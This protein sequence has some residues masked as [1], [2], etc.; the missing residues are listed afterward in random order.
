M[1]KES[2]EWITN[3]QYLLVNEKRRTAAFESGSLY[4]HMI[5]E[6]H[7]M[8]RE[9]EALIRKLKRELADSH[10]ETVNV[11]NIWMA[12]VDDMEKESIEQKNKDE[13]ALKAMELRA[14]TAEAKNAANEEKIRQQRLENYELANR[15]EE[16]K[17]K[18]QKLTAQL[19]HDYENSSLPSSMCIKKKKIENSREKTERKPGGQPGH[20]GHSRKKQEATT[21]IKLPAPEEIRNDPD[22]KKTKRTIKKQVVGI[23]LV[24][25]V[26]EYQADVYYNSKTGEYRHAEFPEEAVCDVNYDGSIKAFLYL[27]NTDC[28]VSIDKCSKFLSDLTA[29]KLKISKGMING[30]GKE[31]TE[32]TESEQK[33]LFHR[34]LISPV[35][36]TDC[37]NGSIN[38]ENAY[39]IVCATPDGEAMYFSR[40][41]KG[42]KAVAGT[43]VEEYQGILVHDHES[44]F[45]NYGTKHQECL[46][47]ILRC[48][49]DSMSNEPDRKWN[50][51]MYDL[52][53]EMIHYRNGIDPETGSDQKKIAGYEEKYRQI[54]QMAKEEYEYI[55]ASQY[56]RDGYN[57]YIRME[58]HPENHLLFLHD[59]RVPANNNLAERTLRN[60]KR[61]QKQAV[62]F[63]SRE[64]HDYLCRGM[65]ML[66]MMRKNETNLFDRVSRIL[67]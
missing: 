36:H 25:E 32:K 12:T 65:S 9:Y 59:L 53:R 3:L 35:M 13:K 55:P 24:L 26:T 64:N 56:Y 43:P 10:A 28:C 33:E 49:K 20:E 8:C 18:N 66:V 50:K 60:Y 38:G 22:F 48:L 63:R 39:V 4:V 42:H 5:Q 19:N 45:L 21:I 40:Q 62:T 29:G 51:E 67:D 16:E 2:F 46:A 58:K 31:F 14:L 61:K 41:N 30:L 27:L 37:T 15:L 6:Q 47:H 34:L 17:G 54:L 57:L 44:T 7:K 11:R 1:K 52:L 23:K